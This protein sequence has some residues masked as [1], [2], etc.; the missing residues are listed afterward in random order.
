MLTETPDIV[1][2]S[3]VYNNSNDYNVMCFYQGNAFCR[4]KIEKTADYFV[5]T[6]QDELGNILDSGDLLFTIEEKL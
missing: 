3:T 2:S 5:I 1:Q 4:Y 6:L